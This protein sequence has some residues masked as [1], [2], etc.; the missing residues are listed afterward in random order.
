MIRTLAQ[1]FRSITSIGP[2]RGLGIQLLESEAMTESSES[3]NDTVLPSIPE[4]QIDHQCIRQG[5][6]D[7][8]QRELSLV[9]FMTILVYVTILATGCLPQG[10]GET[11]ICRNS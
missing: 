5:V 10:G 7:I 6:N 2:R 8:E 11:R 3:D 1:A 9:G 4:D